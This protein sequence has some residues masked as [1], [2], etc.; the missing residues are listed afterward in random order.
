MTVWVIV[1]RSTTTDYRW[2]DSKGKTE[3]KEKVLAKCNTEVNLNFSLNQILAFS[4]EFVLKLKSKTLFN[5]EDKSHSV[6]AR[7]K[8]LD[9]KTETKTVTIRTMTVKV[10]SCARHCQCSETAHH[11][12]TCIT[13]YSISSWN[14]WSLPKPHNFSWLFPRISGYVQELWR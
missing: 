6:T 3:T 1:S 8:M 11:C 2:W 13:D 5:R 10:L 12:C 9:L 14:G 7:T 4:L